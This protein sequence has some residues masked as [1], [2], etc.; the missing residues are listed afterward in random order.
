MAAK[1][2]WV[3]VG[4]SQGSFK[5]LMIQFQEM[6]LEDCSKETIGIP[7]AF[8]LCGEEQ[9]NGLFGAHPLIC[10]LTSDRGWVS[11]WRPLRQAQE[12]RE[13]TSASIE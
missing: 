6:V 5:C 2:Q 8:S 9:S 7:K 12:V 3:V 11:K 1:H 10:P 4:F 13:R